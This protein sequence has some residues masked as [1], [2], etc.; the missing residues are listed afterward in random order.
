M[1]VTIEPRT[2]AMA[3]AESGAETQWPRVSLITPVFNSAHYLEQAIRSVL[4]QGYPNLEYFIVDGGST[5]GSIEIIRKY[6]DRISG[7]ISEPDRG[8]YDA[9]NK[10]F[11]R[12]SGEIMGWISA[13]DVLQSRRFLVVGAVFKAFPEVEWITGIPPVV[14]ELGMTVEVPPLPHWTRTRFLLGANRHIQQESTYWRRGLW[15]R[16]GGRTE[17]A[18]RNGGDF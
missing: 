10:G 8:M 11:G 15:E 1:S 4:D 2:S 18:L 5:D 9:L 14:D 3:V 7:W 16:A 12:S 6:E 13:T 17:D